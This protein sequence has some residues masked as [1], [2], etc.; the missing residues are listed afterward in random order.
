[1]LISGLGL[2][3]DGTQNLDPLGSQS[4][5]GG[6]LSGQ[7]SGGQVV[8][9]SLGSQSVATSLGSQSVGGVG[10]YSRP[11]GSFSVSGGSL[12]GQSAYIV[13]NNAQ[14]T[15]QTPTTP[16]PRPY[17][18]NPFYRAKRQLSSVLGPVILTA[19]PDDRIPQRCPDSG[20]AGE[21]CTDL[22]QPIRGTSICMATSNAFMQADKL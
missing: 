4:V 1:M 19:P 3:Q 5:S 18:A 12:S 10:H 22:Y 20:G 8:A 21:I 15:Q 13:A 6:S 16:T 17:I 9:T 7:I 11:S 14:P 2:G